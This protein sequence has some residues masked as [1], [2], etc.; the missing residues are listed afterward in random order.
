MDTDRNEYEIY[1]DVDR[2]PVSIF[3]YNRYTYTEIA[4]NS[5][6][7]VVTKSS[8][9]QIA[10]EDDPEVIKVGSNIIRKQPNSGK[11]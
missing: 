3:Y 6:Y 1:S 7:S 4:A 9:P 2:L 8:V 5:N 10:T 11:R